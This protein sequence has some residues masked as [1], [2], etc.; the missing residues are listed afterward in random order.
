TIALTKV[1]N[2]EVVWAEQYN[3]SLD[4]LFAIQDQITS[5]IVGQLDPKLRTSEIKRISGKQPER[6][7][8]HDCVLRAIYLLNKMSQE[9]FTEIKNLLYN[10]ISIDSSYSSAYAWL[11][12]SCLFSVGQ[13]WVQDDGLS[14]TEAEVFSRKALDLDPEDDM[15][16]TIAGH[17]QSFAYHNFDQGL[18]LLERALQLN[19]NSSFAW[20]TSAATYCYIGEPEEALRRLAKSRELCPFD[21][22]AVVYENNYSVAY[23]IAER[24]SEAVEWGRKVTH[25]NPTFTNGYKPLIA[26]LGHLGQ[27]EEAREYIQRLL[28]LEPE[29]SISA[30]SKKY[31]LQKETDKQKYIDGLRK[32]GVPETSSSMKQ[33]RDTRTH[34]GNVIHINQRR[35]G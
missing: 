34:P 15:A 14:I 5:T 21:P 28:S 26:S 2:A 13:G 6:L 33:H 30:F 20:A 7:D 32:A 17:L 29:F 35:R 18:Q 24:Y 8:A 10:A 11:S 4:E 12:F 9:Y 19:P 1:E 22:Y 23:T 3:T 16:L 25:D 31:P 27:T